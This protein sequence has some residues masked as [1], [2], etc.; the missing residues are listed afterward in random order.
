MSADTSG[1]AFPVDELSQYDGSVC[2]QHFGVTV[3]D[4][5]AA[6][7][8]AAM[9]S[10]TWPDSNERPEIATRAYALADDML[11]ERTQ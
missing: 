5:F 4:Y 1:P 9:V 6:K 11:K 10:G 2:A 3:R 7:A 8:M